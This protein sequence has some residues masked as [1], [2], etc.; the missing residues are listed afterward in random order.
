MLALFPFASPAQADG[1]DGLVRDTWDD[2][3]LN[4]DVWSQT[5]DGNAWGTVDTQI[6]LDPYEYK[7]E[8]ACQNGD[9]LQPACAADLPA[10]TEGP[11]GSAVFWYRRIRDAADPM[12]DLFAGPVCIYSE[13]PR[14]ILAEIAASI[15][16]EFQQSPVRPAT[17]GS[18]PGPNALR[19]AETNFYAVAVEQAF[20][21]T[22][23]GQTVHINAT[24]VSYTWDYGDGTI[25]GPSPSAGAPLPED[26]WGEQTLTSHV[27]TATGKY[28]IVVTTHFQGT[29]SVNAGPSLPIPDE[30]AFASAPLGLTV[31]RAVTKNYADNCLE[32][33][34]GDGC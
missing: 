19:G 16:H 2:S 9:A 10:C 1:G 23:L 26:R 14:D 24:P 3:G 32:N 15:S 31:W 6:P 5:P 8:T 12:W 30:G 18:Q 20:D 22:L 27:Y 4:T 34:S 25:M 7:Y 17:V 29:Y 33:P 13:K 21:L 11:D 28:G